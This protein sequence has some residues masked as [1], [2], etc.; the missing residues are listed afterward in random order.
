MVHRDWVAH[1]RITSKLGEGGMGAVYRATDTKLNRDVAIKVLPEAFTSDSDRLVRFTREAQVLASLNHP[2]IA[3]IHGF[4]DCALILEL[5]EGSTLADRI[6]HGPIPIDEALPLIR[7]LIDALEYAHEKG[8]IHRDLKPANIKIT[9]EGG[10]KVLDFGLAKALSSDAAASDPASS[11]TLT[12]SATVAGVLLGTAAYMSPE[13]AHGRPIDRGADIW[14]F[15]AVV[16]EMLTGKCVFA[17]ESVSDI[18]ASVLKA[19]PDWNALPAATPPAVRRV[20]RQ[21]LVKDRKHRLQAIADARIALEDASETVSGPV[22]PAPSGAQGRVWLAWSVAGVLAVSSLGAGWMVFRLQ[23]APQLPIRAS[24]LPPEGAQFYL[25]GGSPGTPILSP[26]GSRIAF[27][28]RRQAQQLLWVRE[29]DSL[30]ARPLAGTE[31]AQ[32]PFWSPDSKWLGYFTQNPGKLCK[33]EVSGGAPVAL[34]DAPNGKGGS[35][36]RGGVI[37]FTPHSNQPIFKVPVSGGK[38]VPVTRLD[39][40]QGENSHR[41]PEFLPDG[42]H[43]LFLARGNNISGVTGRGAAIEI[44]SLDGQPP[45]LLMPAE[46][47][48][49]YASGK[50]LFA[51]SGKLMARPLDPDKLAFSGDP[52]PIAQRVQVFEDIF[53][54]I[55][56]ASETGNLIYVAGKMPSYGLYWLDRTGHQSDSAIVH[57]I[58]SDAVELA[59]DAGRAAI[60]DTTGRTT[61]AISIVDLSRGVATR[62]TPGLASCNSPIWSPDG[63]GLV[64]SSNRNGHFDL[65]WKPA[66]DASGEQ[67][68]YE[69][70]QDKYP[71]AWSP[72]GRRVAYYLAPPH[73]NA[74]YWVLP[75]EGRTP[76]KASTP[77]RLAQGIPDSGASGAFSPDSR[78]FAYS[79]R[80]SSAEQ[81]YVTDLAGQGRRFQVSSSGGAAPRWKGQAKELFY[82][83]PDGKM[84]AVPIESSGDGLNIGAPKPLF[85]TPQSSGD[86]TYDVTPDGKRFLVDMAEQSGRPVDITL[87]IHWTSGQQK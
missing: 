65:Y 44:G 30:E 70:D 49:I 61:E 76:P 60:I 72:D 31:G 20:L 53:R 56:S 83:A 50:L 58:Y 73:P 32:Y 40:A 13:Q 28:A 81:V 62:F 87:V 35:W 1:Y 54:G 80:E 39:A 16:F 15:G 10:L 8:I 66:S 6:A 69:S 11:P 19:E 21:C 82:L 71:V 41:Y 45:R 25:W 64:F 18:L 68:L 2:N 74:G 37:I 3:A 24:V 38:A 33:I 26:D 84:M 14:S 12:M 34:L 86:L 9:P 77:V 5:V 7:Q 67:L 47:Q 43:F 75:L 85:D 27:T 22:T 51:Q 55:F 78:W 59:P 17:G 48:A 23:S 57:S 46:S 42:L 36:S 4:E 29:L 52:V 63:A 79:L